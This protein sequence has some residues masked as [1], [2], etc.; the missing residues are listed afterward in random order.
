M[1]S[2]FNSCAKCSVIMFSALFE[3]QYAT[4]IFR[5]LNGPFGSAVCESEPRPLERFTMRPAFDL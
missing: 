4:S 1:P 3:E 2:F 5:S